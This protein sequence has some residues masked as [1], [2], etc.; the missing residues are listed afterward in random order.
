MECVSIS[1]QLLIFAP[2]RLQL[3]NRMAIN[4][5]LLQQFSLQTKTVL[6]K[7]RKK[8]KVRRDLEIKGE[9][10]FYYVDPNCN[11]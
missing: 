7:P 1:F 6:R 11:D 3:W 5:S 8:V 4:E 2:K 10:V 9:Y